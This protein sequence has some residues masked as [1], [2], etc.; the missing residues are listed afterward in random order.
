MQPNLQTE[1]LCVSYV[2]KT[3]FRIQFSNFEE[4]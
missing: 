3:S 4:T 2:Y 1:V